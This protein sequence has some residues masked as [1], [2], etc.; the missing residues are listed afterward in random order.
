M[1]N[2]IVFNILLHSSTKS[3]INLSILNTQ[4]NKM[5]RNDYMWYIK[6]KINNLN[7]ENLSLTLN[8]W[9]D[10][11]HKEK[12][13]EIINNIKSPILNVYG[14]DTIYKSIIID[15][16]DLMTCQLSYILPEFYHN[17]EDVH[18]MHFFY[19]TFYETKVWVFDIITS[20]PRY[21]SM[22]NQFQLFDYLKIIYRN[23][24]VND[25]IKTYNENIYLTLS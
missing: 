14:N 5:S 13:N 17:I 4:F 10:L 22:I 24:N 1:L 16:N 25:S 23:F 6:F 2:D 19:I 7:V 12:I 9:I 8:Q 21:R 15:P 20:A 11:Y 3:I 18:K